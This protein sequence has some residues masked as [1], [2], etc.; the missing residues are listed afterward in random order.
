MFAINNAAST[1]GGDLTP[2]F[3]DRGAHP[4]LQLSPPRDDLAVG[5]SPA[6][7]AQ[8][9]RAVEATVRELLAA[10]QAE[11]KTQLDAGRVDTVFQ[12]GDRV[13][14]RTK[15]LLDDADI[16]KLRPRWD[17]P[18]TVTACPSPNAYTLALPRKM[19]CSPTVNVDRLKPFFERAGASPPPGPV[20]DAGRA[21]EHE[22]ELLLNRQ[23]VRGVMHYLVRWR[24]HTAADDSWLRVEELEHC[25][26]L[27]AEY[28]AAAPRHHARRR[29]PRAARRGGAAAPPAPGPSPAAVVATPPTAPTGFRLAS[30]ADV[31]AGAALVGQAVLYWWPS[32]GWV[33]GTVAR[34][35]R[36][37]GFSAHVVRCGRTSALGV[38]VTPSLL[39]AASHGPNGRWMLL[40]RCPR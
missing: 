3:V 23:L 7:Y 2:F 11:R 8:R 14:L 10:A 17:G 28:D 40:R 5:E 9:M 21:G 30:P 31:L 32:D 16:G 19:R 27:V 33:R 15:E 22:V 13:L 12:V 35:S 25:R 29:G 36:T 4:R 18:F 26:D 24:G 38:A 34:R 20:S 37:A 1:L 6:H 39:D